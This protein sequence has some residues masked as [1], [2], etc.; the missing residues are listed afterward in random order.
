MIVLAVGQRPLIPWWGVPLRL[1]SGDRR[2][3]VRARCIPHPLVG[4]APGRA[5]PSLLI[6]NHQV[7][8]DLMAPM[9]TLTLH[10]GWHKP[11]I[12]ASAKLMYEPGFMAVR[13][14]WLW[15]VMKNV[16]LGWLFEGM[17]MLPLENE[18]QSRSIARWAWSAQRRHGVLPLAELF[19]PGVLEKT[20][21]AGCNT[22]R[23][24]FRQAL[25]ERRKRRTCASPIS[26]CCI[27]KKHSTR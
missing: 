11:V 15:R 27:A 12:T 2:I 7:E 3:R 20:G 16:N 10:G 9:A 1:A 14:P 25:Q 6:S 4:M 18:L 5:R 8:L 26:T 22:E 21:F 13:I 17:G 19:K 24:L 23:S